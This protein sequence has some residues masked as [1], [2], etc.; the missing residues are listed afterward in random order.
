MN[1]RKAVIVQQFNP[2]HPDKDRIVEAIDPGLTINRWLEDHPAVLDFP[3]VCILNG[4]PI[5]RADW[6]SVI[7]GEYVVVF[8]RLPGGGLKNLVRGI[9]VAMMVAAVLFTPAGFF[10]AGVAVFTVG[11]ALTINPG[12]ITDLFKQETP[13]ANNALAR[14]SP[15]YTLGAQG[16]TARLGE[17]IPVIYGKVNI[18]PDFVDVPYQRFEN[19][20]QFLFHRLMLGQGEHTIH[21]IRIEDTPIANFAEIT[22]EELK[23]EKP[24]LFRSNVITAIEVSNQ[25]LEF[26]DEDGDGVADLRPDGVSKSW[27]GPFTIN[28]IGT[29]IDR[30]EIDLTFPKGV[31]LYSGT[32]ENNWA[33]IIINCQYYE[34]DENDNVVG[35]LKHFSYDSHPS[36]VNSYTTPPTKKS[37]YPHHVYVSGHTNTPQRLTLGV[38]VPAGRYRIAL[39]PIII[40]P[41]NTK[42]GLETRW[43]SARGFFTEEYAHTGTHQ[44]AIKMRATDNLSSR[45]SRKVNVIATGHLPVWTPGDGWRR[46]QESRSIAWAVADLLRNKKYGLGIDD[47]QIDLQ[48]F[49]D[50]DQLFITRGDEFNAV[51]DRQMSAWEAITHILKVGRSVPILRGGVFKIVRDKEQKLPTAMFTQSNM[52]KDSFAINYM[53]A[54]ED[55]NDGVEVEYIDPTTWKPETLSVTASGGVPVNPAK[56][57]LMGCTHIDH[58]RREGLYAARNN[59]YRRKVIKF[60]TE[61]EGHIPMF[62]DLI[63]ISH[64]MPQWAQSGEVIGGLYS[65]RFQYPYLKLDKSYP[66]ADTIMLSLSDGS[67]VGPFVGGQGTEP[68]H[69]DYFYLSYQRKTTDTVNQG[70]LDIDN[71]NGDPSFR[72]YFGL[73]QERTKYIVG[74]TANFARNCIVKNIRPRGNNQIEIEALIEDNRVHED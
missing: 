51:F 12:L 63:A 73:Q 71:V 5:M 50:M 26:I 48:N 14:P 19:N 22:F 6:D 18:Y 53:M 8:A 74:T 45:S 32:N 68:G 41:E 7:E 25:K 67:T 57:K 27:V 28:P 2:F 33:T 47:A 49:Y 15:T 3:V 29:K 31:Y 52:V 54:N 61:L 9:G 65:S 10:W 39:R 20:D 17:A 37:D 38:D 35:G 62:G 30:I 72:V 69:E 16:N 56:Q 55:T 1:A 66:A 34:I 59:A 44:L 24:T 21:E 46:P 13:D 70:Y 40:V 23:G 42:S 58:A 4:K 11:A 43:A 64:D 36:V 60:T